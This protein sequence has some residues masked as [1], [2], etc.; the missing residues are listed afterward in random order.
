MTLRGRLGYFLAWVALA[1]AIWLY[2]DRREV[3]ARFNAYQEN[4]AN[5]REHADKTAEMGE[6]VVESQKQIQNLH[7]NPLEMESAIRRAKGLARPGEIVYRIQDGETAPPTRG[8]PAEEK[9]PVTNGKVEK[10]EPALEAINPEL[11]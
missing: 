3:L 1:A 11:D 7:S 8:L 9:S 6:Q 4:N 2:F 10:P 5:A